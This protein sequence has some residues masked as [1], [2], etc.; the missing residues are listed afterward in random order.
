M[1]FHIDHIVARQHGGTDEPEN[2]ALAC[3]ECN[4]HK[5][6]NLSGRDPDTGRVVSL[7]HPRQDQWE[8][9]L[10]RDGARIVGKT[11]KGRTTVWLLEMN[12]GERLR[13][14]ELLARLGRLD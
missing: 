9:H 5:G 6:T 4:W 14:R 10:A 11:A 13:W 2:V 1:R 7:F 8:E 12:T 3:S